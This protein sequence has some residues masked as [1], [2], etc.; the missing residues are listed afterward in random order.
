MAF[1]VNEGRDG[2]LLV[3]DSP[4]DL[5]RAAEVMGKAGKRDAQI[6]ANAAYDEAR[7]AARREWFAANGHLNTPEPPP[8]E[9]IYDPLEWDPEPS[10]IGVSIELLRDDGE[11]E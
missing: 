9:A 11:S 7:R 1:P 2:W 4:A 6:A 3:K 10:Q 8:A 5:D